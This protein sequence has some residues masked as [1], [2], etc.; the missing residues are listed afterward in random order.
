MP[1]DTF[2]SLRCLIVGNM[3]Y[4]FVQGRMLKLI[5]KFLTFFIFPGGGGGGLATVGAN[6]YYLFVRE[7]AQSP[8][9]LCTPLV[10]SLLS[11]NDI[12]MSK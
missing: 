4:D 10:S 11:V 9:L 5:Q 2:L 6:I 3:N 8:P 1:N 7:E 12:F